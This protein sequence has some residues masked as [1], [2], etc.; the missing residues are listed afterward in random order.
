MIQKIDKKAVIV[1]A[2]LDMDL[3][4][5]APAQPMQYEEPSRYPGVEVDLT[6]LVPQDVPF[7][8]LLEAVRGGVGGGA[9]K[10]LEL[11]LVTPA[12]LEGEL[13]AVKLV[14]TYAE[15]GQRQESVTVRLEFCSDERTLAGDEVQAEV[16]AALERLKANAITLKS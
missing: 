7:A 10:A 4:A 2:E 5:A 1:C 11:E 15:P 16:N 3:F 6:L 8:A 13:R 9:V 12:P 14:D